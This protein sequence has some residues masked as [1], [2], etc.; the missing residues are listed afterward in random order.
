M[1]KMVCKAEKIIGS[2]GIKIES[3]L[4]TMEAAAFVANTELKS[5][6]LL[7]SSKGLE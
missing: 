3:A 6:K 1:D 7:S 2:G 5:L 4:G